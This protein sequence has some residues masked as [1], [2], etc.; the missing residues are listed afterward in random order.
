MASLNLAGNNLILLEKE[1]ALADVLCK[2]TTMT[3]FNLADNNLWSKGR[4]SGKALANSPCKNTSLNLDYNILGQ[5]EE[6]FIELEGEKAL[7]NALSKNTM[8]TSLKLKHSD[9]YG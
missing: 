5:K 8:L 6:N 1:K 7:A 3:S 9:T 2:Y 4:K